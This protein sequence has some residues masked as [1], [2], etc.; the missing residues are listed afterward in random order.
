L[1][2]SLARAR[3]Q[4]DADEFLTKPVRADTLMEIIRKLIS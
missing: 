1:R 2:A 3:E 4:I